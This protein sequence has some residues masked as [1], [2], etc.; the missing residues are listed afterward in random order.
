SLNFLRKD[1]IEK[2]VRKI[3][4][5]V[6]KGG[7]VFVSV[8]SADDPYCKKLRTQQVPT[9]ENTF[10]ISR[11]GTFVHYFT[12][13]E[14]KRLFSDMQTIIHLKGLELDFHNTPHYHDIVYYLG[15]KNESR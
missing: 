3:T 8:V 12:Y 1:E 5:G 2:V 15:K 7:F 9:E 11:I 4:R 10:Y 6:K 14:I 13:K